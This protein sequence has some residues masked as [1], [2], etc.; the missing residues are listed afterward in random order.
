MYYFYFFRKLEIT[1]ILN[2]LS[3]II[4]SNAY[5]LILDGDLALKLNLKVTLKKDLF[6]SKFYGNLADAFFF[7]FAFYFQVGY[8]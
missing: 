7:V 1:L 8:N 3:A 4:I 2:F 5:I 6:N